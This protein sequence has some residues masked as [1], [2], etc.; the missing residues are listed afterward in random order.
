MAATKEKVGMGAPM[1][2]DNARYLSLLI[3]RL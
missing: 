1:F 2:F 3:K